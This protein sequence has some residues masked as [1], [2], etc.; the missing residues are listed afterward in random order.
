MALVDEA[1]FGGDA[2]GISA[3]AQG[4]AGVVQPR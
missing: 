1:Q 3:G 2:G 4:A